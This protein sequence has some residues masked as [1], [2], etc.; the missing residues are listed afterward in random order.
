MEKHVTSTKKEKSGI[1]RHLT[2]IIRDKF[3]NFQASENFIIIGFQSCFRQQSNNRD[4][5]DAKTS[6]R[7][8][9]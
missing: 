6:A 3:P 4:E 8:D 9:V 7:N 5:K 2:R 1:F